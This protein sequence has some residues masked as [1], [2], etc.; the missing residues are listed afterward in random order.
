MKQ[1]SQKLNSQ[2]G[3]SLVIALIFF[4]V[5]LT[6]GGIV[7]TAA[8]VNVGR[9]TRIEG[10][11]QAYFAV[12]SAAELL[13]DELEGTAFSA[14]LDVWEDGKASSDASNYP[15]YLTAQYLPELK[16][17]DT[18]HAVR[19]KAQTAA[20]ALF[21]RQTEAGELAAQPLEGFSVAL[22]AQFPE[23]TVE[24]YWV[25]GDYSLNFVLNTADTEKYR[26]PMTLRIPADADYSTN[27]RTAEWTTT[28]TVTREDG[29][30]ASVT[31]HH[32]AS[33]IRHTLDV[34]WQIG[35]VTKGVP[36]NAP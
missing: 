4:L 11:Q 29:S 31:H 5:C 22:D 24:K 17:T 12:R 20:K 7:L 27:R 23:V 21:E 33:Y 36:A 2:S 13:R 19:E 10:E 9:I 28:S 16:E 15:E 8:S 6:V 26:W 34:T 14:K 3:A 18:L 1:V 35:T 25:D 30:T 32:S